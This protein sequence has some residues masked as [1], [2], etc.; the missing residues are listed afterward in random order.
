M[1]VGWLFL[2]ALE[3]LEKFAGREK[4]TMSLRHGAEVRMLPG[5]CKRDS[6]SN[7]LEPKGKC[8]E[9]LFVIVILPI[10]NGMFVCIG[11]TL[12]YK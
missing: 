6:D 10:I 2:T 7:V 11:L 12:Q 3:T 4:P 9:N 5:S 1:C 8:V